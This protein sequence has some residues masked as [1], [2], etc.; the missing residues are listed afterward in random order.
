MQIPLNIADTDQTLFTVISFDA[1]L[2]Y[3]LFIHNDQVEIWV[4][5]ANW[6]HPIG[7]IELFP[8][9]SNA[10]ATNRGS[11]IWNG[12]SN[13]ILG[14]PSG[15]QTYARTSC[16]YIRS[17]AC[18]IGRRNRSTYERLTQ[19][20]GP[21]VLH[22]QSKQKCFYNTYGLRSIPTEQIHYLDINL[23]TKIEELDF[24]GC[25]SNCVRRQRLTCVKRDRH[26]I[27]GIDIPYYMFDLVH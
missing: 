16:Q 1:C 15:S 23:T 5:P 12:C 14:S 8:R 2:Q 25:R 13:F 20:F 10:I 7:N 4:L 6:F 18:S 27:E 22:S 26:Q 19:S 17:S 11:L 9:I 24:S 3:V 21:L